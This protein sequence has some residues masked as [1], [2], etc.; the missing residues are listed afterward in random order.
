MDLITAG[1]PCQPESVAGKRRGTDD[2]RWLWHEVWRVVCD[3][4]PGYLFVENVTGHLSGT[5]PRVAA[6]LA[7]CGW[8]A[9]WDCF[10]AASVGAPHLRDRVFC[11]AANP[12]S[13]A[14]RLESERI[15]RD[16]RRERTSE[17]EQTKP[18]DDGGQGD[19][20]HPDGNGLQGER[21]SGEL[22]SGEWKE[23][24]GNTDGRG[25]SQAANAHSSRLEEWR[26]QSGYAGT[27]RPSAERSH[28]YWQ[29]VGAPESTFRRMDDG[30]P[31]RLDRD[32]MDRLHALGNGVVPQA[33]ARAWLTLW[34]RLH[35][36][37]D[38]AP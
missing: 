14:L 1:Y 2:E 4:Q 35:E 30:V 3:V 16:R 5:F 9:E 8:A 15:E 17:R 29:T 11:L 23:R 7:T 27:E 24:G 18:V 37:N 36:R 34:D 21:S 10:P 22:D 33:A 12:N 32:W 19:A 13:S 20:A 28:S 25:G 31:D 26:S 6:D 38:D